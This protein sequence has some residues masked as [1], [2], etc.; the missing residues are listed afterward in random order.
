MF[1]RDIPLKDVF[2]TLQVD[3]QGDKTHLI[4]NLKQH[5]I[6]PHNRLLQDEMLFLKPFFRDF[7]SHSTTIFFNTPPHP[8]F[9]HMFIFSRRNII[10]IGTPSL[11]FASCKRNNLNCLKTS[12]LLK[13]VTTYTHQPLPCCATSWSRWISIVSNSC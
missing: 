3:L 8:S 5:N 7:K 1:R 13:S 10:H 4:Q 6:T 9:I 2:A 11:T 12:R